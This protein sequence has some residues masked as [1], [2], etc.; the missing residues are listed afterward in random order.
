MRKLLFVCTM[1]LFLAVLVGPVAA[2]WNISDVGVQWDEYFVDEFADDEPGQKDL[3][4]LFVTYNDITGNVE[5]AGWS[6]DDT[7]WPGGNSGDTCVMFDTDDNGNVD[8]SLCAQVGNDPLEYLGQTLYYCSDKKS[9]RCTSPN[10]KCP[11]SDHGCST[12][13]SFCEVAVVGGADPFKEDGT[14]TTDQNSCSNWPG[15]YENDTV[16]TCQIVDEFLRDATIL[17]VCSFPSGSPG[18][19]PS[20]C[21]IVPGVGFLIINKTAIGLGEADYIFT[22]GGG[23]DTNGDTEWQLNKGEESPSPWIEQL[24]RRS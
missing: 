11:D 2:E 17:N 12:N 16:A 18:S 13:N 24:Q 4:L 1:V 20:D 5:T 22:L 6:W 8:F 7:A 9:D 21:V 15:C 23:T 3:T 19:D 14:H 10:D